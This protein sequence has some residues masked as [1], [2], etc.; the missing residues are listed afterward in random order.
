VSRSEKRIDRSNNWAAA[1]CMG[2]R[3]GT[4]ERAKSGRMRDRD[5]GLEKR[6]EGA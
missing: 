2:E 4:D 6:A 5:D 3:N 1:A